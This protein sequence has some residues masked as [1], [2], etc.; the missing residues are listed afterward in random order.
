MTGDDDGR[1]LM[2]MIIVIREAK[3]SAARSSVR[4][5]RA[6]IPSSGRAIAVPRVSVSPHL[7]LVSMTLLPEIN[8]RLDS[9]YA[10]ESSVAINRRGYL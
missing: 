4:R 7:P 3:C 1:M 9:A 2:M 8:L 6:R 5:L 10:N